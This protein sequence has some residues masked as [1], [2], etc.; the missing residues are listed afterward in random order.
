MTPWYHSRCRWKRFDVLYARMPTD[1]LL[2]SR[3]SGLLY[4]IEF[5]ATD[6]SSGQSCRGAAIVCVQGLFQ[7]DQA[8][9]APL[10]VSYDAT[11]CP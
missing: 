6:N 4:S 3:P 7:S 9:R 5:T 10:D 2:Q 8:C 1:G 11:K